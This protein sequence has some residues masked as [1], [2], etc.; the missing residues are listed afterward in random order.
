MNVLSLFDGISC[1]QLA[2]VRAGLKYE[3]Y[4]ASEVD[5]KAIRVTQRHYP[6]TIQLGDVTNIDGYILPKIDLL[7]GGGPCQGFSFA[8][9]GLNFE[10]PRSKLFFE[11]A[12]IFRECKPKYFL[13]EN[14]PMKKEHSDIINEYLSVEPVEINSSLLSA[15]NRKRLYWTNIPIKPILAKNEKFNN[16][17]YVLGHG[18]VKD[19]IKYYNKY[20]TLTTR[21][22]A[23]T[24]RIVVDL[25]RASIA[26]IKQLRKDASLTRSAT[27]EEC[28][29]FQTLPI[30]YT[31]C[32]NKK[33]RYKV[34]GNGWT[35][36]VIAHILS[37]LSINTQ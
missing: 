2:L 24:Y 13:F 20:P 37:G 36:D 22:P 31:S 34:I 23:S 35:V 27:P 18:R 28:E 17:L 7:M 25:D 16:Y 32:I 1:G 11:F 6:N 12:R 8:G 15:Q 21:G 30:G 33:H 3:K 9:K 19:K 26:T 10:D 5:E 4:Y 29:F 14:V